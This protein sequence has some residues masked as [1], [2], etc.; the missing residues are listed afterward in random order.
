MSGW[1]IQTI[2]WIGLGVILSGALIATCNIVQMLVSAWVLSQRSPAG[3]AHE[4]WFRYAKMA[5]SISILVPAYNEAPTIVASVRA[6]LACEYPDFEVIVINDGSKDE[7]ILKLVEALD[8]K[9]TKAPEQGAL[10]HQPYKQAYISTQHQNLVVLDKCN[11]GKADALN[12]GINAAHGDFICVI[13]ADSILDRDALLRAVRYFIDYP[14]DVVAVG[15]AIR[16]TN[17]CTIE[18]GNIIA[19]APPRNF[20][21]LFQSVEY[22]RTFHLARTAMAQGGALTLISG[23]FGLFSKDLLLEVGGYAHN[24]VGEDYELVL[25]LHRHLRDTGRK[26]AR[27]VYT[28][29]AVCWTQAPESL[30][31]LGRQRTRWQRGSL[32]TLWRHR[33]M[34]CNPRYGRVAWLSLIEAIL[35]DIITPITEVLGYLL[36]PIAVLFGILNYGY[37][38]AFIGLSIGFGI[39]LSVGAIALEEIRFR[40]FP[41]ASHVLILLLAAI[42]ENFGYRQLCSWWRISGFIQYFQGKKAWGS[43]PRKSLS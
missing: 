11:G 12:A 5:P 7:T 23:A 43:M 35:S 2:E 3:S 38:L 26:H 37:W 13:D 16:L 17:G 4:N 22:M 42:L 21:A 14:G 29:D 32:E 6:L 40:R 8:L 18:G 34:I 1:I 28:P 20:L 33:G 15:G 19:V 24:T 36:I 39:V 10:A 9:I 31:V 27:I 25:R 41:K 30:E